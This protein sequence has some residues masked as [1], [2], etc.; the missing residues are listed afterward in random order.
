MKR[1]CRKCGV[2]LPASRYF[3]CLRCD[4]PHSRPSEDYYAEMSDDLD[5]GSEHVST[6]DD[7][8]PAW[9][10]ATQ[11]CT[12]CGLTKPGNHFFKHRVNDKPRLRKQCRPCYKIRRAKWIA[13]AKQ[14]EAA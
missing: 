6:P 12:D 9:M 14:K 10:P 1:H 4:P 7:L 11:R 8:M 3:K 5:V 13:N 2:R